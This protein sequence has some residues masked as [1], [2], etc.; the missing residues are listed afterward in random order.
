MELSLSAVL[1]ETKNFGLNFSGNIALNQNRVMSLGALESIPAYSNWASTKLSPYADFMVEPGQPLGNVYGYKV[2]GRYEVDDFTW[3]GDKNKWV[4]NEGVV[5]CSNAIGANFMRPGAL[6]LQDNDG[7]GA[8]DL[9][10]IGNTLP[11]GSGGFSLSGV[12]Y[13]VDFSANFNYVFGNKIYNANKVEFTSYRDYWRR[14]LLSSMSPDKRWCN[15]DWQTGEVINDPDQLREMNAGT[16]MWSPLTNA[17]V[18]DWAMEDGSFLRLSTATIG[19][20]LPEALTSRIKMKK[21]RFYVTGTNLF[22]L[23]AYSGFDPEVDS[24]RATPLTPG[25]DY[26]A[27]PKSIGVVGGLNITF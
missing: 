11:L 7:D 4:L 20:T 23:T 27:Y 1:V 14:N 24:R 18:T 22:C 15:V 13:G 9:Q 17:V 3:D 12:L 10:I 25:V 19:Y 21:L 5:D 16:T 8:P 6:K 26:S 2:A